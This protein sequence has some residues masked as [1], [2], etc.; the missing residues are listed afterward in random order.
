VVEPSSLHA[1]GDLAEALG[2][3]GEVLEECGLGTRSV[4]VGDGV[5]ELAL[6]ARKTARLLEPGDGVVNLALLERELGEGG[7]GNVAVGVDGKGLLA[8]RLG[9][10]NVLL[11]LEEGERLVDVGEDVAGLPEKL[12][13]TRLNGDHLLAHLVWSSSMARSKRSTDSWNFCWSRRISP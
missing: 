13:V 5:D 11:P 9:G 10:A 4:L 1:L 8:Q 3:L 12:S 6:G 2:V 7:N